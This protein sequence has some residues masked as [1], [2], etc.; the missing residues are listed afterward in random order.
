MEFIKKI[1]KWIKDLFKDCCRQND[2]FVYIL[3]PNNDS[4]I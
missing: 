3:I 4:I 2:D 1:F